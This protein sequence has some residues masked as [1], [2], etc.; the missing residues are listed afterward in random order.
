MSYFILNRQSYAQ[1]AEAIR[2]RRTCVAG[3]CEM[4]CETGYLKCS[5]HN[6]TRGES[7]PGFSKAN[8]R[9]RCCIDGCENLR[10]KSYMKCEEHLQVYCRSS[11]CKTLSRENRVECICHAQMRLEHVRERKRLAKE[12][13]DGQVKAVPKCTRPNCSRPAAKDRILCLVHLN[14]W[15]RA[16][17]FCREN[18]SCRICEEPCAPGT[19]K[20][21]KH[22]E[23]KSRRNSVPEVSPVCSYKNYQNVLLAGKSRCYRHQESDS[24]DHQ[25][26]S[27]EKRAVGT[28]RDCTQKVV[29]GYSQCSQHVKHRPEIVNKSYFT[30]SRAKKEALERSQ[31]PTEHYTRSSAKKE[32]LKRGQNSREAEEDEEEDEEEEE[33]EDEDEDEDGDEEWD[34]DKE[35]GD[36]EDKVE[37]T[38]VAILQESDDPALADK[39]AAAA[40]LEMAAGHEADVDMAVD[41]DED[42]DVEM[43]SDIGEDDDAD[44][45]IEMGEGND[46][47]GGDPQPDDDIV[48]LCER[49]VNRTPSAPQSTASIAPGVANHPTQMNLSF[50][51]N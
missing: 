20:C 33:D 50:L 14:Q 10:F 19:T 17:Q 35:W 31:N 37:E 34:E 44:H 25:G 29:E 46:N 12:K 15:R 42:A 26:I 49:R 6:K 30:R 21:V 18:Q 51:C 32:A 13:E 2:E 45:D 16:I 3:N 24:A 9:R 40:L 36:E 48:V 4:P 47:D 1:E 7:S 23:T 41:I 39:E 5:T 22:S 11:S 38:D 43:S 27:S 8:R 28:C